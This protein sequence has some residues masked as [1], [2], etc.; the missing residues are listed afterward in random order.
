MM[1]DAARDRL[2]EILRDIVNTDRALAVVRAQIS[3]PVVAIKVARQARAK[4]QA[5]REM[6]AAAEHLY[7][8][9]HG[10]DSPSR[11]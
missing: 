7:G 3:G 4:L 10:E 9:R 1:T 2:P 8:P 11:A 6:T 5:R